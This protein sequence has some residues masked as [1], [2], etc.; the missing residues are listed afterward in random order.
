MNIKNILEKILLLLPSEFK[1][2]LKSVINWSKRGNFSKSVG[3]FISYRN[4]YVKQHIVKPI[5]K[6]L[7]FKHFKK[8]DALTKQSLSLSILE[9]N[10]FTVNEK[11][12][13][14]NIQLDKVL[15]SKS[16]EF[17]QKE[18]IRTRG[19]SKYQ[20]DKEYLRAISDLNDIQISSEIFN[21][22]TSRG[23]LQSVTRYLGEA[24][25][26]IDLCVLYSPKISKSSNTKN[27]F[28][29][30]Q[31]F[32]RDGDGP[33]SL[34]LWI[35]CNDVELDDGPTVLLPIETSD[36]IAHQIR[37]KQG[38]KIENDDIFEKYNSELF[39]TIGKKGTCVATDTVSCFH[40]GSRTKKE[41]ERLV[42]MAQY[43]SPYS[44]YLLPKFGLG[45][46]KKYNFYD[47]RNLLS[48]EAK[49]LLRPFLR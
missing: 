26:L 7:Y 2:R 10:N 16:I 47:N 48:E 13:F 6:I 18:L 5:F 31:L 11:I 14:G 24:P 41:G 17:A 29:G 33:K 44:T 49:I 20:G 21:L 3:Q 40:M 38:I 1:S 37:Y 9:T 28:S 4:L 36:K 32:H 39:Y 8:E 30:S 23:I 42:I 19:I 45:L 12:G 46:P 22:F 15:V 27:I 25:A 34:K 43:V 35:L